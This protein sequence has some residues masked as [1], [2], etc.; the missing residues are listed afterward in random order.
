MTAEL[1]PQRVALEDMQA[2]QNSGHRLRGLTVQLASDFAPLGLLTVED[3][4]NVAQVAI[5]FPRIN[6]DG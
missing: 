5:Y 2:E 3:L 1:D 6:R 4:V